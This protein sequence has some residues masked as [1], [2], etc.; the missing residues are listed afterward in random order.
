MA[1]IKFLC[2]G[3]NSSSFLFRRRLF[4]FLSRWNFL[5]LLPYHLPFDYHIEDYD[6]NQGVVSIGKKDL[7]IVTGSHRACCPEFMSSISRP[8][9]Y[10][11]ICHSGRWKNIAP[12]YKSVPIGGEFVKKLLLQ[13]TSPLFDVWWT[14]L[15][16]YVFMR[17]VLS[18]ST[19]KLFLHR[20]A[21]RKE[22][23]SRSQIEE[24]VQVFFWHYYDCSN[25]IWKP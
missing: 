11:S 13:M 3:W 12:F 8:Y 21:K 19:M 15:S 5:K 9:F 6:S 25:Y 24:Y 16:G 18:E 10:V 2:I 17:E 14:T 4:S 1:K 22:E 7:S 23:T 20:V